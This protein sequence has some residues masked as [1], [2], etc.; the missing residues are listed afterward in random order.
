MAFSTSLLSLMTSTVKISTRTGHNNYGEGTFAGSTT[1]Y[2]A[3]IVEKPG[4]IRGDGVE[5]IAYRHIA[6]VRSTGAASIAVS[7]RFTDPGGVIRPIVGVEVYPDEDGN[8]HRKVL[9]GY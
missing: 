1:K 8:H 4:Y 3:R 7:D 9:L 5:E 2:R 6:W